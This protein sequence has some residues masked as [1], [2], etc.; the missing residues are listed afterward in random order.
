[1]SQTELVK[2]HYLEQAR[3]LGTDPESTMPDHIVRSREIE[4]IMATLSAIA[5]EK[6]SLK[7][8]EIGCGNGTLLDHLHRAG[9]RNVIGVDFLPEFVDLA[10][11]R[12]LPFDVRVA[13]ICNLPFGDAEFDVVLSERVIINVKDREAQRRAFQQVRRVL[14]EGGYLVMIE[15]LEDGWHNLNA[16]R[17]DFGLEPIPM[18]SQNRWFKAGELEDYTRG[19][20]SEVSQIQDSAVTPRNFLSSHYFMT[21]VVHALLWELRKSCPDRF[22][23]P[24]RNTH[25]AQFFASA[26]PPVGNYAPV[27]FVCMK[28]V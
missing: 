11:S 21:R 28:A 22:E 13:D 12:G 2:Q 18:P 10:K 27:Q 6:G 5:G 19:I 26:L 23:G 7:L 8:L 25:F 4:A 20:L 16:A 1:M 17:N 14:K 9:Y 24:V 3:T 15:A